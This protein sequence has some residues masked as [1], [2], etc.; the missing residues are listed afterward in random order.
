MGNEQ[1]FAVELA[2]YGAIMHGYVELF[3]EVA[4]HPY[5]VVAGE[6]LYLQATIAELGELAHKAAVALGH[7]VLVLKPGIKQIANEIN[8]GGICL[9]LVQPLAQAPFARYTGCAIWDA[10]MEIGGE[11]NFFTR[12]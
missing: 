1:F 6:C 4:H 8:D 10:Q 2:H 3:L 7:N 5:I 9:Y 11:I 12:W